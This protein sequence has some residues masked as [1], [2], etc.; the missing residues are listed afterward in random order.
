MSSLRHLR[1]LVLDRVVPDLCEAISLSLDQR[2]EFLQQFMKPS[3]VLI[4]RVIH[5]PAHFDSFAGKHTDNG[6]FTVLFQQPHQ[7]HERNDRA[8]PH[9]LEVYTRGQ[10]TPA[11]PIEGTFVA[12]VGD[13][14]QFLSGGVLQ[15]TPHRVRH[16]RAREARI[17]LPFFVYPSY[18]SVVPVLTRDTKKSDCSGRVVFQQQARTGADSSSEVVRVAE[19]MDKN[20]QSIWE[21]QAGA[22]RATQLVD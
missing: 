2:G 6:L 8:R 19:V 5:Y 9:S 21:D 14:L 18:E 16:Q 1:G 22:G 12:N 3:P 10:W 4:Q 13:M 15:S 7:P 20:F 17:S 11:P